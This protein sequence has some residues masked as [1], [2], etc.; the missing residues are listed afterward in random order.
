MQWPVPSY[1]SEGSCGLESCV[2][3]ALMAGKTKG[4][5]VREWPGVLFPL[6]GR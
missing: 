6:L 1:M 2:V 3:A 5:S 4:I